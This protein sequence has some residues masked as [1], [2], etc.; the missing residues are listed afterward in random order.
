MASKEKPKK[1]KAPRPG[2]LLSPE[3]TGGLIAGGGHDFQLRYVVCHLPLWLRQ[4]QFQQIFFEGTGDI[5]VRFSGESASS[6]KHI[7][8][9]DHEVSPAELQSVIEQFQRSDAGM[10]GVYQSFTLACPSLSP[11]VRPIESAVARLRGA[12]PF[13]DDVPQALVATE[14]DLTE[15]LRKAGLQDYFEF[16][17]AKVYIE[18]GHG[19]LRYDERAVELFISRLLEHPEYA[20]KLRAMVAPAFAEMIRAV[21]ARR[22]VVIDRAELERILQASVRVGSTGPASMTIW[23][24]NWTTESFDPAADY[25]LDWS[26]HFDRATRRVPTSDTWNTRLLPELHALQK[27]IAVERSERLIHFRGKCA[28]STGLAVGAT[29]PLVGG[30]TFEVPQP[31]SREN[32]R[33]DAVPTAEYEIQSETIDGTSDATDLILALN[34]KGDGRDD[35]K[36][37]VESAGIRGRTYAFVA[38]PAQGAQ[39][40]R[41]AEDASAFALAVRNLLGKLQKKH[42]PDRTHVFFYGPLALAIFVGQQLTSV[43]EVQCYEY[44]DPGYVPSCRFRT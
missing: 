11:A 5:D 13:Y 31:P 29:F 40:I 26:A 24:Q 10:P 18:I 39:A 44:Q 16:I 22:G 25:V 14:Q 15:R 35:V 12:K 33:S 6:R 8:V 23:I 4:G 7:Q 20:G 36:R 42:R 9:K 28:L 17:R 41:G 3:A 2:S 1:D 21:S 27:R 30:W 19:D 34:I 38:P 37:Y 32:W 43:G